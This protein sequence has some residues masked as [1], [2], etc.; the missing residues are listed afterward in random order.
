S[1][2]LAPVADDPTVAGAALAGRAFA[3]EPAQAA[4]AVADAVRGFREG[5]VAP[6]AK[7]FPG[8]GGSTINTD[9]APADVAGRP[10]LAPFAAAIEAEAPLVMLSHARYPALDAERIASQSRPIVEGLLREELGFRGVA[11]TDS[12]EAAASTATGTL[13]VTAERSIRAGVDLLLT[14]GRGSYLRIYRR[15]ETL[16][17]RSPAFA[18]R[19][20]EAAGRVRALQSDLGDRR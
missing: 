10:D 5:G 19:V 3:S 2:T 12:M 18:A 6:T 4:Q 20:R 11:V 17:R 9:D 7:H 16:A 1:V 8:L 15:L 14:T 13:E